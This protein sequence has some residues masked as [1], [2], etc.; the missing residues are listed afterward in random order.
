LHFISGSTTTWATDPFQ[1]APW[2][3]FDMWIVDLSGRGYGNNPQ[4][5]SNYRRMGLNSYDAGA[6]VS[7]GFITTLNGPSGGA[8]WTLQR[9]AIGAVVTKDKMLQMWFDAI[10]SPGVITGYFVISYRTIAV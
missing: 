10:G 3:L 5:G 8:W 6:L 2:G 7:L 9:L 1:V 4:N